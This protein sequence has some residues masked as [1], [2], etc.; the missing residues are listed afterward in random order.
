MSDNCLK[1]SFTK[2]DVNGLLIAIASKQNLNDWIT[3]NYTD[4]I[5]NVLRNVIFQDINNP[6]LG[7]R[8]LP[9]IIQSLSSLKTPDNIPENTQSF[10][11]NYQ[12]DPEKS[13]LSPEADF[14]NQGNMSSLDYAKMEKDFNREIMRAAF[15]TEEGELKSTKDVGKNL[16]EYRLNLAKKLWKYL[17]PTQEFPT[18]INKVQLVN[19]I[20]SIFENITKTKSFNNYKNY[21]MDYMKLKHFDALLKKHFKFINKAPRYAQSS[22]IE[23]DTYTADS[24]FKFQEKGSA[25]DEDASSEDYA[26]DFIKKLISCFDRPS[27]FGGKVSHDFASYTTS[28]QVFYKW[29]ENQSNDLYKSILYSG[30]Q[31]FI[32]NNNPNN[33]IYLLEKFCND[34][35]NR[36]YIEIKNVIKGVID[37][38]KN[39]KLDTNIKIILA[40]LINTEVGYNYIAVRMESDRSTANKRGELLK[41][42]TKLLEGQIINGEINRCKN[43]LINK[44]MLFRENYSEYNELKAKYGI[45]V[46]RDGNGGKIRTA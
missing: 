28:L 2:R 43:S 26:S 18:N 13:A 8:P 27:R 25:Y 37:I 11:P 22:E 7:I 10:N 12:P 46:E 35:A 33:L 39:N 23:E 6:D 16:L 36:R 9:E 45:K 30:I 29:A 32:D 31:D 19:S 41:I 38:F 4:E 20:I 42:T 34:P 24:I 14:I 3:N 17:Y 5:G 44:I 40:N 21:Y 15:V 1:T